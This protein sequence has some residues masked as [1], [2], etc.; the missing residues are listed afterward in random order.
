MTLCARVLSKL[1]RS[2]TLGEGHGQQ[3][4]GDSDVWP[5]LRTT[6]L[7]I[8]LVLA[9][10]EGSLRETRFFQPTVSREPRT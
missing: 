1:L 3:V 5:R 7:P 6:S 10:G 2:E 4:P 9:H 8:S